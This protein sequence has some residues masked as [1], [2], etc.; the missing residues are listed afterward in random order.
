MTRKDI[1]TVTA[2]LV[3]AQERLDLG[4][5]CRSFDVSAETLLDMVEEGLLDPS[6]SAPERWSF[7]AA[8]LGRIRT[9]L[10]LQEDLGVNTAGAGLALDL[11]DEV[12]RL[13]RRV[14]ALER[15]LSEPL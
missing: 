8:E 2:V 11:L 5:I 10:R 12:R 7:S 14:R 9:A 15:Q 6:G 4:E 3:E 13:R 1:V